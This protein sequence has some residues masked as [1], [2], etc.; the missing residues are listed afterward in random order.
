MNQ[1]SLSPQ[2][3]PV[4]TLDSTTSTTAVGARPSGRES[5]LARELL[6]RRKWLNRAAL[7][8]EGENRGR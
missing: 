2:L 8:A 3:A 4:I 7:D 6:G 1:T 5:A